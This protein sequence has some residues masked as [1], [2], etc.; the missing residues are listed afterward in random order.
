MHIGGILVYFQ[1]SSSYNVMKLADAMDIIDNKCDTEYITDEPYVTFGT[2]CDDSLGIDY[3]KAT[4]FISYKENLKY[5]N[6]FIEVAP[7]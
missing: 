3:A 1:I 2:S 4:V 5:A 6:N 7:I